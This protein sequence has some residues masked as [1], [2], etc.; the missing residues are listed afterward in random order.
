MVIFELK[1]RNICG[2]FC[3]QTIIKENV[4]ASF[5]I[6][7]QSF[8]HSMHLFPEKLGCLSIWTYLFQ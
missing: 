7:A 1:S 3:F 5:M 2:V 6:Q 4:I 8:H